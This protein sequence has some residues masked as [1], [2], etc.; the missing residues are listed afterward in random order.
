MLETLIMNDEEFSFGPFT[1]S[2]VRGLF[3][4]SRPVRMP[5][6]LRLVLQALLEE[7][8]KPVDCDTL[9]DLYSRKTKELRSKKVGL[10]Q[11][12]FWLRRH[13]NDADKR[14]V[15]TVFGQLVHVG[16][17][18]GL[19]SD[20]S[21]PTTLPLTAS[22]RTAILLLGMSTRSVGTAD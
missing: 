13:L 9:E 6:R 15:Q 16:G 18:A 1:Y 7:D 2:P 3:E 20:I 14:I 8:G 4:G 17:E 21:S 12:T 19:G 10:S 11:N 22:A 5:R